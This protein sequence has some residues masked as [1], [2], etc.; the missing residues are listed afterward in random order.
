MSEFS[1]IESALEA[2]KSGGFVLVADDSER[3]S[4]GALVLAASF[5]DTKKIGWMLRHT[6]GILCVPM[7]GERLDALQLPAMTPGTDRR[8]AAYTVSVDARDNTQSGLFANGI[9]AS[10]RAR[11]IGL[12]AD[13][14]SQPA[15]L[16]RPG[17]IFPLRGREG[18]VLTRA[19]HTEAALDLCVMA[20]LSPCAVLC[21]V[22]DDEGENA[23]LPFLFEMARESDLP[24]ISIAGLISYRRNHEKLVRK[25]AQARLPTQF[26]EFRAHAYE[27]ILDRTPYIALVKGEISPDM[28]PLVRVHSGCLPGDALTSVRCDCGAQLQASMR[29]INEAGAGVLL[30]IEHH[31][32]RGIGILNKIRAYARQ[33]EGAQGANDGH[34]FLAPDAREYGI[35]AQ[36]LY[37]LGVRQMRLLTNNPS[38]RIGL[39][40]YGLEIVERVPL[41]TK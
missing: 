32:G 34:T 28:V 21:E 3:E 5:A 14:N 18:G 24:I 19:G 27:S 33:D 29:A 26:G 35:G 4:S 36:V 7:T 15:D 30:Y 38:K 10:G 9:S 25:V 13:A 40:G 16:V 1:S 22:V 41:L 2:L 17:H 8:G 12:L 20:G 31:E 11:A 39:D 23:A 6:A 37:D